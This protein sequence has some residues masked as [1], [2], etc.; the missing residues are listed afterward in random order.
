MTS[1]APNKSASKVQ[2]FNE[3]I[4]QSEEK[5][6]VNSFSE[7]WSKLRSNPTNKLK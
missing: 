2:F 4:R 6:V 1:G 3:L 5:N 7:N